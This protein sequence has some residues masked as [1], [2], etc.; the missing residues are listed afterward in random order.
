MPRT[1]SPH[2]CAAIVATLAKGLNVNP[3][4]ATSIEL[5]GDPGCDAGPGVLCTRT[6]AFVV[7]VRFHMPDG[8][9]PE[10]SVSCGV[11]GRF[12]ILCT[13]SPEVQVS[14]PTLGGYFDYPSGATP[15]PTID[16]AVAV[17]ARQLRVAA[18]DIPLDRIGRY[19]VAIGNATLAN[20]IL[21]EAAFT[22]ANL[23]PTTYSTAED[24]VRIVVESLDG[25]PRF[26]N[27]YEHG[28]RAGVEHVTVKL[29]FAITSADPGAVMPVRDI[30]VR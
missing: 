14:S 16:P 11:G 18:M 2:R 27:I 20:G 19:S 7:R 4:D 22:L 3:T 23:H 25:G 1:L 6:T 21:Q 5:L 30:V 24:G 10:D 28:W 12:T 8:H 26:L 15:V 13:E 9:S 29:E 17:D